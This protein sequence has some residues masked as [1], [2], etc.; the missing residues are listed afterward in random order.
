MPWIQ[1]MME[2]TY[3]VLCVIRYGPGEKWIPSLM[4]MSLR[5]IDLIQIF[6]LGHFCTKN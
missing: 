5:K 4:A 1:Y 6:E 2:L 3:S